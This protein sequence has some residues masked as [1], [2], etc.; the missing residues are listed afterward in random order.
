MGARALSQL[1]A[2]H[3]QQQRAHSTHLSCRVL[4]MCAQL[5]EKTFQHAWAVSGQVLFQANLLTMQACSSP[6]QM[7]EAW[8][9]A[10]SCDIALESFVRGWDSYGASSA[11]ILLSLAKSITLATCSY[12]ATV[13]LFY[14]SPLLVSTSLHLTPFSLLLSRFWSH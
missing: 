2:R 3:K 9:S 1:L 8:R 12:N 11:L 4:F 5:S 13:V 14:C 10:R 6:P 7:R